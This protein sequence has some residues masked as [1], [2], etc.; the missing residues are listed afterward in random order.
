MCIR[1]IVMR[2]IELIKVV[3]PDTKRSGVCRQLN[4]MGGTYDPEDDGIPVVRVV[5]DD[6]Q[7]QYVT[8]NLMSIAME[9]R[10]IGVHVVFIKETKTLHLSSFDDEMDPPLPAPFLQDIA[11]QILEQP[12]DS[13]KQDEIKDVP[14][15]APVPEP[16]FYI[17]LFGKDKILEIRRA[18]AYELNDV[19]CI[20]C[21]TDS[22]LQHDQFSQPQLSAAAGEEYSKEVTKYVYTY[23]PLEDYTCAA[24]SAGNLGG[25]VK[26]IIHTSLPKDIPTDMKDQQLS[27]HLFKSIEVP[28]DRSVKLG[29]KRVS[30]PLLDFAF[31]FKNRLDVVTELLLKRLEELIPQFDFIRITDVE[32]MNLDYLNFFAEVHA[33]AQELPTIAPS[34]DIDQKS[35]SVSPDRSVS[36]SGGNNMQKK[37]VKTKISKVFVILDTN[38]LMSS[39]DILKKLKKNLYW[40]ELEIIVPYTTFN[41]IDGLKKSDAETSKKA[42]NAGLWLNWCVR[43]PEQSGVRFEDRHDVSKAEACNDDRIL[44]VAERIL[45]ENAERKDNLVFLVTWDKNLQTKAVIHKIPVLDKAE[46]LSSPKPRPWIK[47]FQKGSP[48]FQ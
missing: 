39:L 44:A 28:L 29:F 25:S 41:E 22:L 23:G 31:E 46:L 35:P 32:S 47:L 18:A 42:R 38:V 6:K 21:R 9:V 16:V 24:L 20:I 36:P 34:S 26:R 5:L 37:A 40:S 15:P 13:P 19:D 17:H 3:L 10:D 12:P 43:N 1:I 2:C 11:A 45:L 48:S 27:D 33:Q 14:A 7:A 4:G 30:I 8:D